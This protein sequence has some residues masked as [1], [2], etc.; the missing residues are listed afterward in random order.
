M[1]LPLYFALLSISAATISVDTSLGPLLLVVKGVQRLF[2]RPDLARDGRLRYTIQ[3]SDR[4]G[5]VTAVR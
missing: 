5:L 2:Q 1:Q 3:Y 4:H